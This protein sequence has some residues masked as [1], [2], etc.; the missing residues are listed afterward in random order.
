VA[1]IEVENLRFRYEG[2]KAAALCGVDLSVEEGETV[3]L[4][5]P[6]GSGKSTLALCLNGLI[7]HAVGGRME[8]RV[9][10]AGLDTRTTSV[11]ELA[12][13]VGVVFQD[14]EAQFVTMRVED[15]VAFGLENLCLPPEEMDGRIHEAL[16][17]VGMEGHRSQPVDALSGGFKQRTALASVLAMLPKVLVFDEPTSNLDP[18]STEEF[19]EAVLALK[20]AGGFTVVLIEHKLD[21]LMHLVD[22]VVVLAAGGEHLAQGPP[23][24]VFRDRAPELVSRGV[25][26]PQVSLLA[27]RLR[28]LGVELDPFP[29]TLDEGERALG[30]LSAG[31]APIPS[32]SGSRRRK[33]E[34]RLGPSDDTPA[35]EARNLSFSYGAKRVL[36]GVSLRVETGD[37][38]AIVG[39]NGA[40]KTT[41]ARH[42]VGLL[43]PAEG[44]VEVGGRDVARTPVRE[45]VR[46]IGYVFQNPEHQ[47]VTDSVE[48]EV[49]FGLRALGLPE[50]A[51]AR[52]ARAA[53][54]RFGL[55]RYAGENP[56]SLSHGEKRRLSVATMLVVG[57]ETLVLDEPTFGQD[58]KNA[59]ALLRLLGEL[60]GEG[61]TVVVVTHDMALVAEHAKHVAV[62]AESGLLYHGPTARLFARPDLVREARLALPPLVDLSARLSR[63]VPSRTKALLTSD[64][65][66]QAFAPADAGRWNDP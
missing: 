38:L 25:W 28:G 18:A 32:L 57:Q 26:M 14:P 2:R 43:R 42:F 39:A 40:G 20:R 41:L 27:H 11:A 10:V 52:Q 58:Q 66:L 33:A 46:R 35:I 48:D 5:G 17:R 45:F 24:E 3:L 13:T 22:R 63:L 12:Q 37:F 64:E 60:N 49:S 16:A 15:E 7:P 61:R 19:F 29:V 50:E 8:G 56:F 53:L 30:R 51:V 54:E 31:P 21:R 62:L 34:P 36:D 65:F 55:H 59:E 23:R 9:R 6:S 1:L 44:S 47:F 4:L